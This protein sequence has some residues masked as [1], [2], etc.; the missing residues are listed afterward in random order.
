MVHL[1]IVP[2]LLGQSSN[3]IIHQASLANNSTQFATESFTNTDALGLHVRRQLSRS[4]RA[5]T[6]GPW[7]SSALDV[8]DS[9]PGLQPSTSCLCL[10]LRN[11][12]I[13]P[14]VG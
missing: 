10:N 5:A 7:S 9:R 3:V 2:E 1:M 12:W 14:Q 4:R 11:L 6:L 13:D 8:N